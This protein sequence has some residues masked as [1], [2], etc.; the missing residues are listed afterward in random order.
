MKALL[1]CC[2]ILSLCVS[3]TAQINPPNLVCVTTLFNGD[4][5]LTWELPSNTCGST[6]NG[7]RI[8]ISSD[9][10]QPFNLLNI[11]TDPAQTTFTHTN[12]NGTN[13]T[14][15]YYMTTD[16][17]C[18]NETP[19]PSTILDNQQPATTEIDYVTVNNSGNV[20]LHWLENTSPETYAYIIFWETPS[21]FVTIDTVF[22]RSNT[23]YEHYMADPSINQEAYTIVAM[24]RCGNTGL[25]NNN[26]HSTI[27]LNTT[28]DRCSRQIA[29]NWTPYTSWTQGVSNHQIWL[30]RNGSAPEF[31]QFIGDTTQYIYYDATDGES[32]EFFVAAVQNG[33]STRSMS[34]RVGMNVDV[35]QPMDYIFVRNITVDENN[36]VAIS[37]SW[38]EN[39]DIETYNLLRADT[40]A[41]FNSIL[42]LSSSGN[43]Q[44]Q[45]IIIDT[46]ADANVQSYSYRV[47]SLDS[48][49]GLITS[50]FGST[51]HLTGEPRLTFDNILNWTPFS[52]VYGNVQEYRV[53]KII[54]GQDVEIGVTD[55]LTTEFTE[56]IDGSDEN[57]GTSCYY[58]IAQAEMTYP[59][60]STEIIYTR[61]NTHCVT[62]E[63]RVLMPN[64]FVPSG[65]NNLFKPVLVF[66]ETASFQMRI[67]NRWGGM[68]FETTD[69]ETGWDGR[70]DGKAVR[71]G[72]YTYLVR[73]TQ[74]DGH[75][76]ERT[77]TVM[78]VR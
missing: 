11:V 68:I 77:G 16:L 22:G 37:W 8:Y 60:G 45:N 64:A 51:I 28:I 59:D 52:I 13:L 10:T 24:D 41:S 67:F 6:F 56:R 39:S 19:L 50:N 65:I 42:S 57:E 75:T 71:Q 14:W 7:Y 31:I 15:Y 12:A 62:Q 27:L 34:N 72:V 2:I 63:T 18:P 21:G 70:V 49:G 76:V 46:S 54:D 58:I 3:L 74:T 61:S 43:L 23:N 40:I 32:L 5:E 9:P 66:G 47:N 17:T 44:N 69:P 33:T 36:Q 38:D 25:V 1:S 48:C 35:V 53:Y 73:V 26:P 78:L 30:A 29:L 20:E 4:V 55:F